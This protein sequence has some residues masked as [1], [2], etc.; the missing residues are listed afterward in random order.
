MVDYK[1]DVNHPVVVNW[2]CSYQTGHQHPVKLMPTP[3][4]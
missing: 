1:I 3:N 2:T 4:A